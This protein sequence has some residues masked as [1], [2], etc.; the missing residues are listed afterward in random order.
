[1]NQSES[2]SSGNRGANSSNTDT[3]SDK[4]D[5]NPSEIIAKLN[6]EERTTLY[7]M[8]GTY[9]VVLVQLIT[10]IGRRKK[11]ACGTGGSSKSG[12]GNPEHSK[13]DSG[14][15]PGVGPDPNASYTLPNIDYKDLLLTLSAKGLSKIHF[16]LVCPRL[17][18]AKLTALCQAI[19]DSRAREFTWRQMHLGKLI[20][21]SA[22]LIKTKYGR[23]LVMVN[24]NKQCMSIFLKAYPDATVVVTDMYMYKLLLEHG[25]QNVIWEGRPSRTNRFVTDSGMESIT[26]NLRP[27]LMTPFKPE[28]IH[29]KFHY[30][31]VEGGPDRFEEETYT[32]DVKAMLLKFPGATVDMVLT[33]IG[34]GQ[35]LPNLKHVVLDD[36]W[37]DESYR[38]AAAKN[39]DLAVKTALLNCKWTALKSRKT[40]LSRQ[41]NELIKY[42]QPILSMMESVEKEIDECN[43]AIKEYDDKHPELLKLKQVCKNVHISNFTDATRP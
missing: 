24:L 4:E 12:P 39:Q 5:F 23:R 15:G 41:M 34:D 9:L 6:P 25:V 35:H 7:T 40:D 36:V 10:D 17:R 43:L 14:I 42:A 37:L 20:N 13:P 3:S 8:L 21:V 32:Y 27:T 16:T 19:V 38:K 30:V 28:K 31:N 1:M 26:I 11:A 33:F 18:G 22:S 29:R 2:C